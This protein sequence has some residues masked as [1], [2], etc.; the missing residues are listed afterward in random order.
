MNKY[1]NGKPH[2][3]EIINYMTL[4]QQAQVIKLI[5][6]IEAAEHLTN[7]RI[8]MSIDDNSCW[9]RS[10]NDERYW[11]SKLGTSPIKAFIEYMRAEQ[12]LLIGEPS[13]QKVTEE[14]GSVVPLPQER[15]YQVKGRNIETGLPASIE[16][17]SI[18]V[19]EVLLSKSFD[20]NFVRSLKQYLS[21][22]PIWHHISYEQLA[23]AQIILRES[24]RYIRGMSDLLQEVTG[25]K[26]IIE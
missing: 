23:Q 15:T 19:R 4:E 12:K 6:E 11:I 20:E 3:F 26:V 25:L 9:L 13:A 18:Q 5:E 17:S 24:L 7:P 22:V 8:I 16:I 21:N 1:Y 2:P 10:K 14:I